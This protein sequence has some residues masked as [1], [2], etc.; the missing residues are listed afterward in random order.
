[1]RITAKQYEKAKKI[2]TAALQQQK[3]VK[4]WEAA[5]KAFAGQPVHS[6]KILA[7]GSAEVVIKSPPTNVEGS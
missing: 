6:V 5:T 2:V 4:Q 3:L 7:D 1:M